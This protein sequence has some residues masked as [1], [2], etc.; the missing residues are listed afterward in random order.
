V[1]QVKPFA[2]REWNYIIIPIMD[3]HRHLDAGGKRGRRPASGC[4]WKRSVNLTSRCRAVAALRSSMETKLS[5]RYGTPE[6]PLIAPRADCGATWGRRLSHP[7]DGA[8][9]PANARSVPAPVH[10]PATW[11]SAQRTAV[12][13]TCAPGGP[14]T[15]R[16]DCQYSPSWAT[17]PAPGVRITPHASPSHAGS[18]QFLARFP[19][20]AP[21]IRYPPLAVPCT[22]AMAHRR[23]RAYVARAVNKANASR[24]VRADGLQHGNTR[25]SC[26]KRWNDTCGTRSGSSSGGSLSGHRLQLNPLETAD[27]APMSTQMTRT[28]SKCS[29]L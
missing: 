19:I 23:H 26:R 11:S 12:G 6:G 4:W 10:A 3:Q 8:R 13:R 15:R 1:H 17:R 21:Q 29:V 22:P 14:A 18:P 2:V 9:A 7:V 25:R 28:S 24:Q 5:I 16:I 20:H 27:T